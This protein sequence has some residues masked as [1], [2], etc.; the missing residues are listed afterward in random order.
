MPSAD[1]VSQFIGRLSELVENVMENFT[2]GN[3][4][5]YPQSALPGSI[6]IKFSAD[7]HSDAIRSLR[8]IEQLVESNDEGEFRHQL[9]ELKVDPS[10][11]KD[12]LTSISS[13]QLDVEITPKLASDGETIK[14]L[15]EHVDR[16]IEY[17]ADVNYIVIDSIKI[18]QANDIDKVLVVVKMINDGTPLTPANIGG[19]TAERQVKYYTDAAYALGLTNREK[20]L[21]AAGHFIISQAERVDQYQILADRF[22]STDFGWGWMKWAGVKY[23][24]ELDPKSAAA[25]IIASVPALSQVTARRRASTLEQWLIKL[26]PYHRRYVSE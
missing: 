11:L 4:R 16:C 17:L 18:P 26:K 12:F 3:V 2:D 1:V 20:Q 8:I 10:Q 19:L 23:M 13:N 22:E 9:R 24:T 6:R 25:F 7:S 15:S 5:L 14:L 21:T